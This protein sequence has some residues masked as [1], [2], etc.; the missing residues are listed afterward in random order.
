MTKRQRRVLL[1]VLRGEDHGLGESQRA[2]VISQIVD[3]CTRAGAEGELLD[4]LGL[5]VLSIALSLRDCMT[6]ATRPGGRDVGEVDDYATRHAATRTALELRRRIG[7]QRDKTAGAAS[8]GPRKLR[9]DEQPAAL[10]GP[11]KAP[12][13]PR[14]LKVAACDAV[15]QVDAGTSGESVNPT[16]AGGTGDAQASP[17][18]DSTRRV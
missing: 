6:R 3:A 4:V 12:A 13:A 5:D 8:A 14:P 11:G 2:A 15:R 7:P 16:S 10:L 17:P 1:C 18:S 9:A